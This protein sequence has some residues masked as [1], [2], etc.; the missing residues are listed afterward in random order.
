MVGNFSND[1]YIEY[2]IN[3]DRNKTLSFEEFLNKIRQYLKDMNS[4]KK[5]DTWKI[6][7]A[8]AYNFASFIADNTEDRSI[9]SKID[10]IEIM[11][12][13]EAE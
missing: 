13:D 6:Q 2:K 1:N 12:N 7:L 3:S 10:N 9:H 4:F 5:L 11:I 8:I